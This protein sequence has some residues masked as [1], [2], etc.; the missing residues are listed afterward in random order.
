[1]LV[2]GWTWCASP[3]A[4]TEN[5]FQRRGRRCGDGGS[6]F[7]KGQRWQQKHRPAGLA[8][9]GEAEHGKTSGFLGGGG[10]EGRRQQVKAAAPW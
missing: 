4:I 2:V 7:S 8:Y 9:C 6:G 5:E 3:R 10:P 1:M